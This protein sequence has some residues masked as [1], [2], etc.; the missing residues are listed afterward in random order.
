LLGLAVALTAWLLI[1]ALSGGQD[2]TWTRIR[3][4]GVWRVGMDPSFPPF[5]D[6]DPATQ[7]PIGFDV[8][9]AQAIATRWGVRAEIVGVGFDQLL[10]AVA[11]HRVDSAISAHPVIPHRAQDVA[12]SPPYFEAG[13]LLAVPAGS[14]ITGPGDLAGK[15]VAAEWGSEGDAQARLF[16]RQLNSNLTLVLRPSAD[17]ALATVL[18]GE[19]DAAV[20]DAVSLALFNRDGAGLAAVGEP[21]RRDPYV[22]V[23]PVDAPQLSSA[24]N[25]AL[26]ALKA[27]GTLAAI[28]AKW[29]IVMSNE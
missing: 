19:A 13:V 20:V 16:Q 2:A 24:I 17:A 22:I 1:R 27:D 11:A 26:T 8:D 29:L 4:T 5:E 15:R 12:F 23:L 28:G 9:L 7:Q 25:E 6:L 10:D 21:L 3:E 18:A 14:P